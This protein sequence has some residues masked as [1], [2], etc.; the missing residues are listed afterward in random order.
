MKSHPLPHY[1]DRPKGI[2]I[3]TI[4]IHSMY[5]PNSADIFHETLCIGLLD[6]NKV[7]SHYVINRDGLVIKLVEEKFRA[8]HAGRSKM[9]FSDDS[10]IEVNDF[11]I[12]IELIG[13]ESSGFTDV[14]YISLN[15]LIA[16]IST[17]HSIKSIVGHDVI[18]PGRKVD[19]GTC[20]EWQRLKD[21]FKNMRFT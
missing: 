10:R 16:D 5:C 8:W 18:A 1:D 12:G 4:V 11:S 19:P 3:D 7:A 6:E 20:F 21:K 13:S 9:P 15:E 2:T 17:R 14:Q